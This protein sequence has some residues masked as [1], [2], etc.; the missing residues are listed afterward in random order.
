M[1]AGQNTSAAAAPE[2]EEEGE[3]AEASRPMMLH[4]VFRQ[5][6]RAARGAAALRQVKWIGGAMLGVRSGGSLALLCAAFITAAASFTW[7]H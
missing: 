2:E 5:A 4:R 3:P 6:A 7:R 1:Q